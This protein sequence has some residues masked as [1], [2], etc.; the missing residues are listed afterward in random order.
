MRGQCLESKLH[1]RSSRVF[2]ASGTRR[3]HSPGPITMV[4]DHDNLWDTGSSASVEQNLDIISTFNTFDTR[5]RRNI[6][7]TL[8]YHLD[9][10][11]FKRGNA[12][13]NMSNSFDEC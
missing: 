1:A 12:S 13:G 10:E 4:H 6:A 3:R 11:I 8:Y 5:L 7:S 2:V 9:C